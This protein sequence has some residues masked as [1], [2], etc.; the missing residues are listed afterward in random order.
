MNKLLRQEQT[1]AATTL[2]AALALTY[3]FTIVAANW[4]VATFEPTPVGFGLLAPAGVWFAGLVFTLRDLLHE[5]VTFLAMLVVI[6]AGTALSYILASPKLALASA[7]AFGLSELLDWVIYTPLRRQGAL[8]ALAAS[9][10]V[11]LVVDSLVF[12]WIAFGALTFLPG[13]IVGKL[14]MTL[15]ALVVLWVIRWRPAT[16]PE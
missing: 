1:P 16:A 6:A 7:A 13:Q 11:G 3:L 15:L 8:L 12:L 10:V 14:W 9:N 4:A 5:R 2:T